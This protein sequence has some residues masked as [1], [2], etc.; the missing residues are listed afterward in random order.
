L[1]KLSEDEQAQIVTEVREAAA[2]FFPNEQMKMPAQMVI[3]SGRKP[4]KSDQAE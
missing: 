2:E 3:V 4:F 1:A